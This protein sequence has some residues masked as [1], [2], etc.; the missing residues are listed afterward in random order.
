MEQ[1]RSVNAQE[2]LQAVGVTGA[3]EGI[4]YLLKAAQHIVRDLGREDVH[5]M[6]AG[7]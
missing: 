1:L 7:G 5:F 6:L 4:P 3:Q 2:R